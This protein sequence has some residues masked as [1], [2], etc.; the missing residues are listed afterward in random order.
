MR[1]LSEE[2]SKIDVIQDGAIRSGEPYN[3]VAEDH[4]LVWLDSELDIFY[5]LWDAGKPVWTIAEKLRRPE[6]EVGYLVIYLDTKSKLNRRPG[7]AWGEE[8]LS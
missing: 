4:N 8:V 6:C 7:G 3:V 5:N 2:R 1:S